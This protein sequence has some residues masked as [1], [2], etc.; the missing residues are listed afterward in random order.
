MYQLW[1]SYSVL[2]WMQSERFWRFE[3]D[4]SN[5]QEVLDIVDKRWDKKLKGPLHRAGYFLNPY[6]Y[7]E[8]KLEI[9]LDGTFKDG[10]VACMEKMVRDGAKE[11]IMMAECQAYQEE[12]G[13]FG[14]ESAKRQ[15]R[16]KSFDPAEWWSNHGSSAPNLRV[17]A[18]RILSLTCSSSAC[19]RNFSVFQQVHT[20]RRNR[21]LHDKMCD[22]VFIKANSQ[23]E[24]KRGMKDRDPIE[25]KTYADVVEDVVEDED[26][27]W[28]TGIVPVQVVQT[29]DEPEVE[30]RSV[31]TTSKRK[32]VSKP[33]KKKLLPIFR[34]DDLQPVGSSSE[35]EDDA[36]RSPSSSSD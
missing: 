18:M 36:T 22:F 30:Q 27:E 4:E 23:L 15:R 13:S 5:V 3:D 24:Q 6:Y 35:S 9:E 16:N 34:D 2:F 20:K 12:A 32:K 19:E 7:Y 29:V 1:D 25:D 8:N 17:L 28:I 14:R 21:L 33:K 10:L 26:N 11:D 31:A